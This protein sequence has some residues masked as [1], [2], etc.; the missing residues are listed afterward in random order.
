MIK[1]NLLGL[2]PKEIK[3]LIDELPQGA[4][5]LP[6]YISKQIAEWIYKKH[7]VSFSE[8]TN[9]ST[10]NRAVL[11]ENFSI[12]IVPPIETQMSKDGSSKYLFGDVETVL[13]PSNDRLT[14]CVSSQSGCKMNCA[15]CATGKMGFIRNLSAAE[16]LN[17]FAFLDKSTYDTKADSATA[18]TDE[19]AITNIVL[20]GMG[21]PLD[22]L[23][24]VL[25]ALKA[26]TSDWGFA[27]SPRRITVSTIG[28]MPALQQLIEE[29]EC[30][31]A[32]S[33]HSPLHE[34]RLSLMPIEKA[35]PAEEIIALLVNYDWQH[36]RKLSFEY[37]M[38]DGIN[39]SI[40]HAKTL[41]KLVRDIP[42]CHIN[43]IPYNAHEGSKFGRSSD[44]AIE[45]FRNF[46]TEKNISCTVR[47]SRGQDIDAACGLLAAK[48]KTTI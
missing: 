6:A 3:E 23:S 1:Q 12:G 38:L 21:E 18:G 44:T 48:A 16:I 9:I 40:L 36:Q 30:H 10:V 14:L 5:K 39:D 24:N 46:L 47:T 42:F 4:A 13:I 37:V 45:T 11:D 17:Q 22:N 2:S 25:Q 15:F 28:I 41:W 7:A 31:I 26:L 32:V 29:T 43:L 8:M 27:L 35:Y 19:H 33:L 20:M 34:Q